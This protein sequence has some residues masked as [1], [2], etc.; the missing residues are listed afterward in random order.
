MTYKNTSFCLGLKSHL[1][2]SNT[3]LEKQSRDKDGREKEQR[4]VNEER[5][6]KCRGGWGEQA[7][8][9]LKSQCVWPATK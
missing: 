7:E 4:D 2:P 1:I 3:I 9:K 5:K 8:Y 6:E